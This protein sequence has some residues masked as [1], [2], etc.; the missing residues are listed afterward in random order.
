MH[1]KELQMLSYLRKNARVRLTTVSKKTGVPVSTLFDRLK[2]IEEKYIRKHASLLDYS[3][4]G[5]NVRGNILIKIEREEKEKIKEFL[6]KHQ[7]INSLYKINDGYDY[8]I[9]GIF[10]E[11]KELDDFLETMEDR[12]K[13]RDK[14][15]FFI[16]EDLKKEE[17]L[18]EL[19]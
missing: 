11:I 6:L 3:K 2:Q 5:Y 10:K 14:K 16:V 9:E 13:I 12:F 1:I 8:M 7:N 17:F 18:T 4:I 19:M 15:V